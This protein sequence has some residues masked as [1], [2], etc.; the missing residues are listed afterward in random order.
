MKNYVFGY[1]S[2]TNKR[3]LQK[4]LPNKKIA[5]W[6]YLVGFR[7]KFNAPAQDYLFLNIVPKTDR[8]IKGVLIPV[9]K[10]ELNNLKKREVGY[11]AVD[12]TKNIKY[13]ASGRV[14][15]FIAPDKIYPERKILQSYINVCLEPLPKKEHKKWLEETIIENEIEDDSADPKYK[16]I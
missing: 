6:A 7:R 3:S 1:G 11:E 2:L 13:A 9:S 16:N 15:T 8:I 12:V 14:F 4:T 10:E 5:G